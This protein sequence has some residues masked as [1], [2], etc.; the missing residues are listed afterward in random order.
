[1]TQIRRNKNTVA[2]WLKHFKFTISRWEMSTNKYGMESLTVGYY[3][4]RDPQSSHQ[5][6]F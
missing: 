4:A 3:D 1:M 5:F 6:F 2:W